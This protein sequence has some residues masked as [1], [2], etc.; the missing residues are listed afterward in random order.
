MVQLIAQSFDYRYLDSLIPEIFAI[1]IWSCP[2]KS[3]RSLHVFLFHIF[4]DAPN[5]GTYVLKLHPYLIM[6]QFHGVKEVGPK[7]FAD[8]ALQR[9][10]KRHQQQNIRLAVASQAA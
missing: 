9:W 3:R 2:P 1:E 8:F 4:W 10:R 7:G 5:F 6:W